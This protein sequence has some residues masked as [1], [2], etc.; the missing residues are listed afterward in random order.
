MSESVRHSVFDKCRANDGNKSI[1]MAIE[2]EEEE[3]KNSSGSN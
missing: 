3:K 1:G 2:E